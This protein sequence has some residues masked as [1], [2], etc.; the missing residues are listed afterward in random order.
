MVTEITVKIVAL[1]VSS[2][3]GITD[4]IASAADAPHMATAPLVIIPIR[5]D[6]PIIRAD[7]KPNIIVAKTPVV[8]TM[9]G[10]M[11]SD[12]MSSRVIRRPNKAMPMRNSVVEENLMPAVHLG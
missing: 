6:S 10:N 8:T 7:K 1:L 9:I 12:A 3:S 4:A 2:S 11:P 5:F